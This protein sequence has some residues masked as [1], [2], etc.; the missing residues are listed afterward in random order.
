MKRGDHLLGDGLDGHG[1]D[2]LVA[3][4][5]EETVD[6]R[7]VRLVPDDVGSDVLGREQD[8]HVAELLDAAA[9]VVRSTAGLHHHCRLWQLCEE[10]GEAVP[11]QPPAQ[12]HPSGTIKDGDLEDFL[13]DIDGDKSIVSAWDGLLPL[14]ASNDFGTRCRLSR[15]RSPSHQCS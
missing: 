10:G 5:L 6:I 15:R 9:P 13:C 12:H 8:D 1:S 14:L 4:G 2:L 7:A 11:Q 3:E